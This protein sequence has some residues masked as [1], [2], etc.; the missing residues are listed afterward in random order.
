MGVCY[1]FILSILF[2]GIVSW[3]MPILDSFSSVYPNILMIEG[4]KQHNDPPLYSALIKTLQKFESKQ[5]VSKSNEIPLFDESTYA[6]PVLSSNN[7]ISLILI[8][9]DKSLENIADTVI[10]EVKIIERS[11][12]DFFGTTEGT[13]KELWI[14]KIPGKVYLLSYSKNLLDLVLVY[15]IQLAQGTSH[16]MRYYPDRSKSE[17]YDFLLPGSSPILAL[18]I[19]KDCIVYSVDQ[20]FYTYH[21]LTK[22]IN[23]QGIIVWKEATTGALH[24]RKDF[25][26]SEVTGL[27]LI[28]VN[29]TLHMLKTTVTSGELKTTSRVFLDCLEFKEGQWKQMGV[30]YN[31]SL[32]EYL[33]DSDDIDLK[34]IPRIRVSNKNSVYIGHYGI[35]LVFIRI[36]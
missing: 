23:D 26:I 18:S 20:G 3:V 10:T 17:Y 29:N 28:D 6:I 5:K 13:W 24:N 22:E 1:Y 8:R 12:S 35:Y 25:V 7:T 34:A 36:L 14:N 2:A 33:T 16:K 15:Q 30:L 11:I 32:S 19:Y 9:N 27:K 21:F 31:I 4:L